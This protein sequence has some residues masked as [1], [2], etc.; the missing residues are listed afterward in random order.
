MNCP[1]LE[2]TGDNKPCGRCWFLLENLSNKY[3]C[4]R[5]GDVTEAVEYYE[6]T[7]LM[8]REKL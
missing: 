3:L 4:E 1:I 5:H 8:T 2:V 6:K 7:Q